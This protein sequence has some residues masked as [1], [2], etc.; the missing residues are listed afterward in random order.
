MKSVFIIL[1]LSLSVL[2]SGCSWFTGEGSFFD[3]S[4]YDYTRAKIGKEM[5]VPESLGESNVQDKFIVPELDDDNKG[6]IYGDEKDILA[7]M[8]VLTL[9]NKVRANRESKNA[10]AFVNESEIRLWDLIQRYLEVENIQILSKD[11]AKATIMTDWLILEDDSFWFTNEISAWRYRY[12]IS[13]GDSKKTSSKTLT[14]K[15]MKS[16]E[17]VSATEKWQPIADNNR[18]E[19][20]FL[21]SILG[22]MYIE[23]IETSRQLVDD[24]EFGGITVSLGT[25]KDGNSALVT[26]TKF[27]KLWTRLPISL[28]LLNM[29]IED[30]DRSKGIFY[31]NNIGNDTGFFASLAFWSDD[32]KDELDIPNGAYRIKLIET[33]DQVTMTFIDGNNQPLSE[34]VMS[35]NYPV[36]AKAFRSRT[37]D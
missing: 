33:D 28:A 13:V 34:E 8:Q 11:L 37:L 10:S 16:E 30:Q 1:L 22:F 32:G 21:N 17:K 3:D 7:P 23:D 4:E 5:Q 25:D 19:T 31:I 9:G 36:L 14:I 15:T 29:N 24:S 26:S 18:V 6:E 27:D 2:I 35:E 12:Q 20:E